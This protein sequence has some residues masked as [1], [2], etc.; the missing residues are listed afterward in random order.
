MDFDLPESALAVR[1]GVAAIGARYGLDYWDRCDADKRWPEEAWRDLAD[2]GWLGLA[3]PEEYGG[4]G[5]GLL[6]LA[7][8]TETLAVTGAAGASAFIYLS[9]P[10][11]ARS[12]SPG[13]AP[14]AAGRPAARARRRRAGDLLRDHRAGRREQ[15]DRDLHPA[16]RDGDGLRGQRPEDLD[17][18]RERADMVL[19]SRT[20]PAA[21]ARPRVNGFTVLL[22][23]IEEAVA[24]GHADVPADPEARHQHH[25]SNMVFTRRP[26][27][28]GRQRHRRGRPG[29]R[30]AVGHPQ[31]RAR[32]RG[33]RRRRHRRAGPESGRA[34]TPRTARCSAGR[35]R[36]T[37]PSRSP[38]Q[39]KAQ[40]ELARLMT[41]KAAWLWDRQRPCGSE[42]NI[43]KLTAAA[44]GVAGGRPRVPGA[45]RHGLLPGVSGGAAV[46]RR[47]HRQE[48]PGRRGAGP[49]AHRRSTSW[50]CRS[51]T[52]ASQS[53]G[54]RGVVA[55][56]SSRLRIL[57]EWLR[58]IAS[59]NSYQ[60]GRL[61]PPRCSAAVRVE[62]LGGHRR[63]LRP[64][65]P[66]PPR[67]TA[68][69]ARPGRRRR[70]PP[71]AASRTRSTSAE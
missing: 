13:T 60:R 52:E 4:G 70:R 50:A 2:G 55:V 3:V 54:G 58:G 59:A 32:H 11:S 30:G 43:A 8:A 66:S 44:G 65:P 15:R 47:P 34:T 6:E 7:V 57:P 22:V 1:D 61:K 23:D 53:Y 42:A 21:E 49:G 69:R 18:R 17:L 27:C 29:L 9:P 37:R 64:R 31:P 56:R 62:L 71:D 28:P 51:R 19:V 20:I 46:P 63:P 35:S 16:R 5:Q 68:G 39:V 25:P 12:P 38:R 67:P 41:Y 45:R 10:R 48:H 14:E 40:T 24:A 26:A 33:G 36:P